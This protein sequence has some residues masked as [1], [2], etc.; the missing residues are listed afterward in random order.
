MKNKNEILLLVH[1]PFCNFQNKVGFEYNAQL[2][3]CDSENGGCDTQFVV[4]TKTS[5]TNNAGEFAQT[6][7][8]SAHKIEGVEQTSGSGFFPTNGTWKNFLVIQATCEID[9][10]SAKLEI[11]EKDNLAEERKRASELTGG[12]CGI[13][14]VAEFQAFFVNQEKLICPQCKEGTIG[15]PVEF[16]GINFCS[17]VCAQEFKTQNEQIR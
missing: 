8:V 15:L 11:I 16:N 12:N 1:C 6:V 13:R 14:V 3:Y 17:E 2:V 5:E 10:F 9:D 7:K 4:I